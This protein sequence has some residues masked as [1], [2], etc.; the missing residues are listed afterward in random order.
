MDAIMALYES[1]CMWC[2]RVKHLGIKKMAQHQEVHPY[3]R[4]TDVSILNMFL[5]R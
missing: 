3:I 4:N 2:H 5:P 1:C